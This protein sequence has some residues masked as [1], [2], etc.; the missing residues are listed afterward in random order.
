V[1]YHRAEKGERGQAR[2]ENLEELVS[3]AKTFVP[4][5]TDLPSLQQFLD[6]AALDAGDAQ[7]DPHEDSV[8]LMTL[9]SAKGLEFPMVFLAGMEENLFP[10]RMSLDEPGRLEEERR[11][12]YV[13]ITRAM[14]KLVLTYAES[15]R[16]HGSESYNTASRFV[17]ELPSELLNEV[18][19]GAS[20]SRPLSSL[21]SL[22][23]TPSAAHI[24]SGVSLGQRVMHQVFGEG[25]VTNFEGGGSNARVEVSFAEGSKWLVLQ[26]ANLQPL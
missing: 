9:H 26:Y 3:A 15:R 19:L 18:R 22:S 4:D 23:P 11:L 16:L 10:H 24:E 5:D 17:R 12:C 25:V 2:V 14:Q 21:T 7:A 1:E 13:G 6:S 20:V 8:Q